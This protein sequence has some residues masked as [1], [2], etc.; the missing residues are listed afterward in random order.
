[1]GHVVLITLALDLPLVCAV[2]ASIYVGIQR[3][4]AALGAK[5]TPAIVLLSRR[6]TVIHGILA[7]LAANRRQV[8][9]CE[10]LVRQQ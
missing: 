6:E 5:R 3:C 10:L 9:I 4:T 7:F 1:M 8:Q 2:E